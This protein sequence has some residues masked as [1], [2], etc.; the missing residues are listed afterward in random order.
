MKWLGILLILT[1]G[2]ALGNSAGNALRKREQ[3]LRELYFFTGILKG[4]FQYGADPL[5]Q[6]FEKLAGKQDGCVSV[7]F[8][9]SA[10]HMRREKKLSLKEIL[11]EEQ[12]HWLCESGLTLQEQK[13]LV[14]VCCVLGQADRQTQTATLEGYQYELRQEETY[15]AEKR[16]QK[17]HMYRCL[18]FMGGLFLAVLLY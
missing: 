14:K 18:G 11:E 10:E 2:T 4:E 6:V 5:D 9:K 17:E 8:Q 15:A 12:R 3:T 13:R 1:A 7:F 16:K